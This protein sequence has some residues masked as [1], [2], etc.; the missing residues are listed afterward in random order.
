MNCR[1]RLDHHSNLRGIPVPML[2]LGA[3]RVVLSRTTG[4]ECGTANS[5][6]MA[7]EGIGSNLENMTETGFRRIQFLPAPTSDAD[8]RISAGFTNMR[9][10]RNLQIYIR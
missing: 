6:A 4:A 10:K 8:L 1:A 9:S 7:A 5:H 3:I 2:N